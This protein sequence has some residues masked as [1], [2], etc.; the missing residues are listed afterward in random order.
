MQHLDFIP[1]R[2]DI[3]HS[4]ILMPHAPIAHDLE[5]SLPQD[6]PGGHQADDIPSGVD[7][8]QGTNPRTIMAWLAT[9]MW[10]DA[11][12]VA[13]ATSLRSVMTSS[14]GESTRTG[15]GEKIGGLM[16]TG[17]IGQTGYWKRLVLGFRDHCYLLD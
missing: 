6:I 16:I 9:S 10:V 4:D 17:P 12:I 3:C 11:S 8:Q 7:N 13:A 2:H 1:R 15:W 5:G 14:A